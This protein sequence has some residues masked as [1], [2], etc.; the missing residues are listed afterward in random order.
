MPIGKQEKPE[1]AGIINEFVQ[2]HSI[3][4]DGNIRFV[5]LY[6]AIVEPVDD[7]QGRRLIEEAPKLSAPIIMDDQ[8]GKLELVPRQLPDRDL[9]A[10]PHVYGILVHPDKRARRLASS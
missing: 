2:D 3:G 7:L 1:F 4:T 8:F 6:I 9:R 5:V 10:K